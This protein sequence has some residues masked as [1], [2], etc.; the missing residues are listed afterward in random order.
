MFLLSEEGCLP[1]ETGAP[2]VAWELKTHQEPSP[3][4]WG[5]WHTLR[6]TDVVQFTLCPLGGDSNVPHQVVVGGHG[7]EQTVSEP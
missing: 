7:Y 2:G 6:H 1:L 3:G 5:K 4:I